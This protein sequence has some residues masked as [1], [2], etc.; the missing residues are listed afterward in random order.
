MIALAGSCS[1]LCIGA[2][3]FALAAC[4]GSRPPIAASGALSLAPSA[5][6]SVKRSGRLIYAT[7]TCIDSKAEVFVTGP[8]C[9]GSE[10]LRGSI[11][12]AA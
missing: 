2:I 11:R 12:A 7:G 9:S 3:A 8:G 10:S 5:R 1:T 6:D 4:G